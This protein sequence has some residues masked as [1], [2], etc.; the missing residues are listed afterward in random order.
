MLHL[1]DKIPEDSYRLR[2]V[3]LFFDVY[4]FN[5]KVI[6]FPEFDYFINAIEGSKVYGKAI[7]T[8]N[9][10]IISPQSLATG[11]KTIGCWMFFD[12]LLKNDIERYNKLD[13]PIASFDFC[14]YNVIQLLLSDDK[15]KRFHNTPIHC[16]YQLTRCG[17][18]NYLVNYNGED[19]NVWAMNCLKAGFVKNFN[20][21]K[22][23]L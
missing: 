11:I 14:G 7:I 9:E 13:R 20:Q 8:K 16:S 10:D 2:S 4:V 21:I 6:Q 12:D 23:M 17:L 18:D 22:N 19:M 3:D 1:I 15:F 5:S